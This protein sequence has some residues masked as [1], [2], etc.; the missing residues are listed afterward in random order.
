MYIQNFV[1]FPI[2]YVA[3]NL[4]NINVTYNYSD[5]HL[6]LSCSETVKVYADGKEIPIEMDGSINSA[7][8]SVDIFIIF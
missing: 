1:L 3:T 4:I 6:T 5:F 7:S 8:R 2:V